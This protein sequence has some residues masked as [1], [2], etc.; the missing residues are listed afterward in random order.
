MSNLKRLLPALLLFLT[1]C[2]FPMQGII[3]PPSSH[4]GNCYF[5]ESRQK[6]PELSQKVNQALQAMDSNATG[7]AYAYGEDCVYEDGS[8][9][10][11][12]METDFPV[13]IQVKD[14]HDE[15]ALGD[16]I[17]K[18]MQA[19]QELPPDQVPGGQSGRVEFQFVQNESET[20][21]LI[22]QI[23]RYQREAGGLK[24]TELFQFFSQNH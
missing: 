20:L 1:A 4:S 13:Q 12:A 3:T 17:Y 8:R 6:L 23:G 9:V 22:V 2:N 18:V 19:L 14:I 15:K 24:G 7:R 5:V 16:W 10:F 11:H 21:N